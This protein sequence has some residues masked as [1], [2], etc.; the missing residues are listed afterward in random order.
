MSRRSHPSCR[1]I[2]FRLQAIVRK[3][4][5]HI[6][7]PIAI[8]RDGKDEPANEGTALWRKPKSEVSEESYTEREIFLRELVANAADAVDRR[9]FEALT[10]PDLTL[11]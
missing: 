2:P 5:D 10:S 4:A 7:V 1:A 6:T 3:W 8:A 9:R 11:P